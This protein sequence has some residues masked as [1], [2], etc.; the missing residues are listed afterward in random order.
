MPET[1][2][3]AERNEQIS[4]G[5]TGPFI[6]THRLDYGE[7]AAHRVSGTPRAPIYVTLSINFKNLNNVELCRSIA[8][9]PQGHA[10]FLVT[11]AILWNLSENAECPAQK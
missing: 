1:S 4:V 6:A 9:Y 10:S 11:K 5:F 7:H 8:I 3:Y 2:G